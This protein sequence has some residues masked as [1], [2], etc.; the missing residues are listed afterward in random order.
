VEEAMK[1]IRAVGLALIALAVVIAGCDREITGDVE[2]ADNSS[3][4]C[5][6]CHSD[7]E[8]S[9]T[10]A[11]VQ[12]AHS[13]YKSGDNTNRNRH[14]SSRYESCERCHTHEG[15]IAEV[16]G[17]PAAGDYFSAFGCFTCHAPHS[18]GNFGVRVTS[19]VSLGNG[20]TYN[21]GTSNL[22]ASCHMSRRDVNTYVTDST[23]LSSHFGPH[24]S[25]QADMLIGE[26]GYE[27]AGYVYDPGSWHEAVVTDGCP[28]CHMSASVHET[29][30]GHA[31]NMKNEE[32]HIELTTGCNVDGCHISEPLDSL[33]RVDTVDFDGD[34]ELEGIQDEIAGMV[35]TLQARLLTAGLIEWDDEDQAYVPVDGLVVPDADSAGAVFNWEFVKEDRSGGVH[36]TAYALAL[37]QS[38][39]N[40]LETGDP[41]GSH[42][43]R[44]PQMLVRSH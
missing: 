24:Y 15:F 40:Y 33:N 9:L 30:G 31:W 35:D 3:A 28:A 29:I 20:A 23:E 13:V 38:S 44:P 6:G 41:G 7:S 42:A 43:L 12:F 19:A 5:F 27:Y 37:L 14:Y 16:T 22:C 25:N 32:R 11:Q 17:V 10:A 18:E 4:G 21:R 36:N 26:N 8:F 39:I 2:L 1:T 34:G